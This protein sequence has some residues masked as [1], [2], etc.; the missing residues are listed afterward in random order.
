MIDRKSVEGFSKIFKI[1]VHVTPKTVISPK[2]QCGCALKKRAIVSRTLRKL[3]DL[4]DDE[5]IDPFKVVELGWTFFVKVLGA[6][7]GGALQV[8]PTNS[9]MYSHWQF[10]TAVSQKRVYDQRILIVQSICCAD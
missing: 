8:C 5:L 3:L 2:I 7:R 6:Y 10:V 9:T 4:S 1:R